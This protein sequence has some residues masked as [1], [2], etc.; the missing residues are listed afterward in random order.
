MIPRLKTLIFC[1]CCFAVCADACPATVILKSGKLI[2]GEIIETTSQYIRIETDGIR[3]TTYLD[4]IE[5][6]DGRLVDASGDPSRLILPSNKSPEQVFA[7][8]SLAVVYIVTPD[9]AGDRF[10]ASGFIASPGGAVVTSFHNL[11]NVTDI[12][13]KLRDGTVY[14]ALGVVYQDTDKDICV[15]KINAQNMPVIALGNSNSLKP[16]E[17]VYRMGNP[18]GFAYGLND[19]VFLAKRSVNGI[20]WLQFATQAASD[21]IGGP[22]INERGEAIGLITYLAVD[23]NDLNFA[24]ASN[25]IKPFLERPPVLLSDFLNKITPADYSLNEGFILF[26]RGDDDRAMESYDNAIRLNPTYFQAYNNRG[27]IFEKKGSL[28]QAISDYTK[29]LVINPGYAQAYLN[30]AAAYAA[31]GEADKAI[32]DYT[33]A[34]GLWP[35]NA[36]AYF[37]RGNCYFATGDF[38]QAI[39]DYTT[40][41]QIEPGRAQA[42]HNRGFVYA[43][44]Q[45]YD[46]AITDYNRAIE[47]DS[48]YAIAYASRADAYRKKGNT[49]QALS[50]YSRALELDEKLAVAYHGRA[51]VYLAKKQYDQAWQDVR[52]AR[53]L[54]HKI[55]PGLI[56]ELR[57]SSGREE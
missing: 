26:L 32:S 13:V 38:D 48:G 18:L 27:N 24:L 33:T 12:R 39:A 28:D 4:D 54:G 40:T 50:D 29:A 52:K 56:E 16:G 21:N 51:A 34:I 15:L 17:K 37:S 9:S 35:E 45:D 6:I 2:K 55:D 25:E 41:V 43:A 7:D 42:Y 11:R 47:N 30:R 36:Y 57:K 5:S 49:A 53:E 31:R 19:S 22:L 1:F 44:K 46:Q 8:T 10:L 14:P 20:Q 23:N 3:L